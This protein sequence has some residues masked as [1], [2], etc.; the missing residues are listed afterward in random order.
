MIP[1]SQLA[2]VASIFFMRLTNYR[3]ATVVS[4]G[5]GLALEVNVYQWLLP[6]AKLVGIDPRNNRWWP[7]GETYVKAAAVANPGDKVHY[8]C[9]CRSVRC[10]NMEEH[11]W[12]STPQTVTVD[13]VCKDMPEPF[14]MWLD[15]EGAETQAL[16]GAKETL[17]KTKWINCE[18]KDEFESE[19]VGTLNRLG[20]SERYRHKDSEDRLFAS[21]DVRRM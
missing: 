16:L 1:K 12:T 14:F 7:E 10:E 2:A 17:K 11:D 8:C 4:V 13:E 5:V 3:P 15:C 21:S 19:V 20:F 6:D 9:R 18:V